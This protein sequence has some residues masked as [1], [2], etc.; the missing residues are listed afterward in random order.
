[1]VAIKNCIFDENFRYE[2]E[3]LAKLRHFI[4]Q[5]QEGETASSFYDHIVWTFGQTQIETKNYIVME[6]AEWGS[7]DKRKS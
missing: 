1:M 4:F 2:S 3:Q 7:L 6:W 5:E